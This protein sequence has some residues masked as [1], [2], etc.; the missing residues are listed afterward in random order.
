[1]LEKKESQQWAWLEQLILVLFT[2]NMNPRLVARFFYIEKEWSHI[3]VD[4]DLVAINCFEAGRNE[5]EIMLSKRSGF[6]RKCIWKFLGNSLRFEKCSKHYC[7]SYRWRILAAF[8]RQKL[9]VINSTSKVT[10]IFK[11]NLDSVFYKI[12]S[13]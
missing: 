5:L 6:P 11:P 12:H 4:C 10:L 13:S 2:A 8:Q 7:S 3:R 9:V 1:M